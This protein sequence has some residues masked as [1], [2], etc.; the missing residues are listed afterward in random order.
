MNA[1]LPTRWP[2]NTTT[3]TRRTTTRRRRVV[4]HVADPKSDADPRA[5]RE[6]R[7]ASGRSTDSRRAPPAGRITCPARGTRAAHPSRSGSIETASRRRSIVATARTPP[8][9][10]SPARRSARAPGSA[11]AVLHA[12]ENVA[13][14]TTPERRQQRCRAR[15]AHRA[16][17]SPR[18]T[19]PATARSRRPGCRINAM[20]TVTRRA[21]KWGG[22]WWATRSPPS[23][24]SARRSISGFSASRARQTFPSGRTEGG[25][26]LPVKSRRSPHPRI[27]R[28]ARLG[29]RWYFTPLCHRRARRPSTSSITETSV[30]VDSRT[31][32]GRN[33]SSCG[34]TRLARA[35][36][37]ASCIAPECSLQA[38][39]RRFT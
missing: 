37:G 19:D 33:P 25:P 16:A 39:A 9:R 36:C 4:Q 14:T 23:R 30:A 22:R 38:V 28:R 24:R 26:S 34:G 12:I 2:A 17:A 6:G 5:P 8:G 27:S 29:T 32:K 7:V 15:R 13:A 18:E 21:E 11:V 31:A 10:R 1:T 35:H 3:A 20:P